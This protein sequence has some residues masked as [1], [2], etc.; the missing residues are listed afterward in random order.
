M[1]KELLRLYFVAV[2]ETGDKLSLSYKQK[3]SD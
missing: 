3:V 2:G 1:R